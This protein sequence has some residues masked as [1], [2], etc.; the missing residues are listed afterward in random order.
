[1]EHLDRPSPISLNY[2]FSPQV[3]FAPCRFTPTQS[4]FALVK[5]VSPQVIK[6]QLKV[7]LIRPKVSLPKMFVCD[8][9]NKKWLT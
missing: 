2:G 1:M 4:H 9:A 8:L 5:V 6:P 7:V 3:C